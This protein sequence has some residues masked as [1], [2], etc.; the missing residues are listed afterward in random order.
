M[1]N[2]LDSPAATVALGFALTIVLVFIDRAWFVNGHTRLFAVAHPPLSW[3][4]MPLLLLAWYVGV[5]K[6]V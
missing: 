2:P 1:K 6:A 4:I 3:L 5:K